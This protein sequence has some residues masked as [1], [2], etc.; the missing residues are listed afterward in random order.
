[1]GFFDRIREGL[2]K[3]KQQIVERFDEI[4]SQSEAPRARGGRSMSTRSKRSKS[5]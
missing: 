5:C 4:V 3:T 2:S 1:M